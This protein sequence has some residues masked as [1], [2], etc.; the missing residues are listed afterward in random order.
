MAASY[1]NR[2]ADSARARCIAL[3]S[4]LRRYQALLLGGRDRVREVEGERVR[5]RAAAQRMRAVLK[6]AAET[7]LAILAELDT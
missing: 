3:S 5:C 7:H 6:G 2:A 1:D 4:W